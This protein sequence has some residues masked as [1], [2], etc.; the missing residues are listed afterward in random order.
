MKTRRA[1]VT[2]ENFDLDY[3]I[4][5]RGRL[6]FTNAKDRKDCLDAGHLMDKC[7]PALDTRTFS[8]VELTGHGPDAYMK[9]QK[10]TLPPQLDC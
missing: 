9:S 6:H 7:P 10:N 8:E 2:A 1:I 4:T 5:I 3:T